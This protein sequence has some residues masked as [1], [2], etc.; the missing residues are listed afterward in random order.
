MHL[1]RT[2][3]FAWCVV[4]YG[5]KRIDATKTCVYKSLDYT[6]KKLLDGSRLDSQHNWVDLYDHLMRTRIFARGMN[7]TFITTSESYGEERLHA[8]FG[9]AQTSKKLR[10]FY[11]Q[12]TWSSIMCTD[13]SLR[14]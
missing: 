6:L 2:P 12:L 9:I 3:T 11:G 4:S 14:M 8:R 1:Q 13:S 10:G 5:F 7:K